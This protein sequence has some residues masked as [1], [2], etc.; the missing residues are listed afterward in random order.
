M[1]SLY[2]NVSKVSLLIFNKQ[3]KINVKKLIFSFLV[4]V[5]QFTQYK[6]PKLF[7]LF[8]LLQLQFFL[9][10]AALYYGCNCNILQLQSINEKDNK[11]GVLVFYS[12]DMHHYKKQIY[13]HSYYNSLKIISLLFMKKN[14]FILIIIIM[15]KHSI[16]TFIIRNY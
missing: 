2:K 4:I 14:W 11:S 13:V 1:A 8:I 6:I 12:N 16:N 3:S 5:G 15:L 10:I 7:F 9:Y